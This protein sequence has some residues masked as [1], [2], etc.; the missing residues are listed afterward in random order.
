MTIAAGAIF[1]LWDYGSTAPKHP[2]YVDAL[3]G[4]GTVTR[5]AAVAGTSTL[6]VGVNHG[7]G[8]FGGVIQN[9]TASSGGT[10]SINLLKTGAGTQVLAGANTYTCTTVVNAGS[11]VVDGSLANTAVTVA[12]AGHWGGSGTITGTVTAA[13]TLA[14]GTGIGTLHNGTT[15]LSGTYACEVGG[16]NA[17]TLAVTGDLTITG[18]LLTLQCLANPPHCSYV[19]ASYTGNLTGEFSVVANAGRIWFELCHTGPDQFGFHG[20]LRHMDRWFCLRPGCGQNGGR[21]SGW[22][23]HSQRS[24][25]GPRRQSRCRHGRCLAALARIDGRSSRP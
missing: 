21:R 8:S 17:D 11:L 14:P 5:S 19:I 12:A 23:W 25:N 6:A 2:V 13:G 15:V 7:S 4:A 1:D 9:G 22:R 20:H 10:P 16:T 18:S 24:G 3:N